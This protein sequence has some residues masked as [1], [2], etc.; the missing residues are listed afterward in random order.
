VVDVVVV[1]K[2]PVLV[3]VVEVGVVDEVVVGVTPGRTPVVGVGAT[4]VVVGVVVG[5]TPVSGEAQSVGAVDVPPWPGMS[6]VPAQPKSEN[7]ASRVTVPPSEKETVEED[8][9]MKPEASIETRSRMVVN[10]CAVRRATA[11]VMVSWLVAAAEQMDWTLQ[12][13]KT[14]RFVKYL[15]LVPRPPGPPALRL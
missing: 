7:V 14:I 5:A 2:L 9:R 13:S 4:A 8:S 3:V 11:L 1:V 12:M 6:R 15:P 10:P